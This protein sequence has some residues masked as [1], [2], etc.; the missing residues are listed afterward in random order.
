[1]NAVG[2]GVSIDR[3]DS[4]AIPGHKAVR[5]IGYDHNRRGVGRTPNLKSPAGPNTHPAAGN[6]GRCIVMFH[7]IL[8]QIDVL[9]DFERFHKAAGN[10]GRITGYAIDRE[11]G[12]IDLRERLNRLRWH[13][14]F[15]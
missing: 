7:H 3:C 14:C 4:D 2:R 15:P 1:M 6:S 12:V 11:V 13:S 5:C 9:M 10:I 8:F